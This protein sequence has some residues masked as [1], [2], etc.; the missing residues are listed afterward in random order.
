MYIEPNTKIKIL[1]NCPLNSNYE[2]TIIFPNPSAQMTYFMGLAKHN[3]DKQSYQRVN[4]GKMRVAIKAEELYDCNY[5]MFQNLSFGL[6]WFYA[7]IKSVEYVNNVTSEIEFE[8]DVMQTW[9]FDYQVKPCFVEREH[10]IDDTIGAN[11]VP[12]NLE[13]GEYVCSEMFDTSEYLS[14]LV[15]VIASTF[16]IEV[17]NNMEQTI[18]YKDYHGDM[19]S[20]IF[21]GLCYNVYDPY[22]PVDYA[23]LRAALIGV[24]GKADGIVS[25]FMMPK[26][27]IIAP[28]QVTS[29]T[30]VITVPKN[31]TKLGEY[32]N[33]KNNK[34]FT[35]PYNFLYVSNL[36]GTSAVFPYE[37]FNSTD[38]NFHLTGDM[39][40][41]PSVIMY[42]VYYKG[43]EVNWDEK[44]ALSGFPN[45]AFNTDAFKAWLAQNG[46]SLAVSTVGGVL[47]SI[48]SAAFGAALAS[49]PVGAVA[50]IAMGMA[51]AA[52]RVASS[53]A[54]VTEASIMPN[55]AH[56]NAGSYAL[57]Q[58]GMLNFVLIQKHIKKEFAKIIDDYFSMYGYATNKVKVPNRNGRPHWNYVKTAGAILKGTVGVPSDDMKKI[59]SIYDSG[60][61]FWKKG[62]EI[63][64]YSLDNNL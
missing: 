49:T 52:T 25:I 54:K 18:T 62:S 30:P 36:Q 51:S 10:A 53:V 50:A 40:C 8:L 28:D 38:C 35:Y 4:K 45:C 33:V 57:V 64:D 22:D 3:L 17:A 23:I 39:S 47:T 16:K 32:T 42:P 14:D 6:K 63:G 24:G 58:S 13:L 46:T 7:F 11:T 59:V 48:G 19:H 26:S 41:A 37:F 44:I 43:L 2:H 1:K 27:F 60:I 12:E 61:T 34:L 55:Q 5:L 15:V 20:G 29:L 31:T 9:F 56:G 21:S